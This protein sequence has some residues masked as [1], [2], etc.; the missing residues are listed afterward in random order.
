[1]CLTK[2]I[3]QKPRP[4]S[5]SF[6]HL[7]QP[8]CP[9]S[10][11]LLFTLQNCDLFHPVRGMCI[12]FP[13]GS[14]GFLLGNPKALKHKSMPG[15]SK[16]LF[17]KTP[18]SVYIIRNYSLSFKWNA[19]I[20]SGKA[21]KWEICLNPVW[22]C[23]LS[24]P[25]LTLTALLSK[26]QVLGQT[27]FRCFLPWAHARHWHLELAPFTLSGTS[28]HFSINQNY[29][30]LPQILVKPVGLSRNFKPIFTAGCLYQSLLI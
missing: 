28:K 11:K 26:T 20:Q 7:E 3:R 16:Y 8:S 6:R 23:N 22:L 1:M 12:N 21:T 15:I 13:R 2:N 5:V 10:A 19:S 30:S 29:L 27:S 17:L 18:P 9:L 14:G 24:W 4:L 25:S